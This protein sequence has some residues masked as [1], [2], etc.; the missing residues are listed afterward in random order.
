MKNFTL[1]LRAISALY[2]THFYRYCTKIQIQFKNKLK[3]K[4]SAKE[5]K[6]YYIQKTKKIRNKQ[7]Q[8]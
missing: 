2:D 7:E 6:K 1:N 8:D 4:K 5:M 3:K